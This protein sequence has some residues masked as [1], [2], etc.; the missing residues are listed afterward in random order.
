MLSRSASRARRFP[1]TLPA[2]SQRSLLPSFS[3]HLLLVDS[4]ICIILA[5]ADA[6]EDVASLLGFNIPAIR[7][8]LPLPRQLRVSKAF[9]ENIPED[10]RS[11]AERHCATIEPLREMPSDSSLLQRLAPYDGIDPGEA[12]LLAV[13]A[14]RPSSLLASGDKRFMKTLCAVEDLRDLRDAI[15]GRV[16]CLETVVLMC[17]DKWGISETARRFGPLRFNSTLK[18]IFNDGP[19]TSEEHCREGLRSYLKE[20]QGSLGEGLLYSSAH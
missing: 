4:D 12:Q 13:L 7:R 18:V 20:L 3:E 1:K 17:L 5:A 6:F 19:D 10:I 16:V 8:L 11:I 2:F 14:E 15:A 9:R